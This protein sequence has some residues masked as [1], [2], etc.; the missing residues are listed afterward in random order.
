MTPI[1]AAG[2]SGLWN[3]YFNTQYAT[4]QTRQ[5]ALRHANVEL[6][7]LGNKAVRKLIVTLLGAAAGATATDATAQR[8]YQSDLGGG[9]NLGGLIP[10]ISRTAINR[11]TTA[12]DVTDIVNSL[13]ER[14]VV[15][16]YPVDKSGNGGGGKRGF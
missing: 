9:G 1:A 5:N 11:A 4:I 8:I 6:K 15:A 16:T 12:G 10:I 7:G 3:T 2:Y 13:T 14:N